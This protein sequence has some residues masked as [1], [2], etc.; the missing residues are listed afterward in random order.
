M[1]ENAEDNSGITAYIDQLYNGHLI[2]L[3]PG[4][5]GTSFGGATISNKIY[6]LQSQKTPR[7]GGIFHLNLGETIIDFNI[8]EM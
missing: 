3:H 5:V 7:G 2:V 6:L 1:S 8:P 4:E